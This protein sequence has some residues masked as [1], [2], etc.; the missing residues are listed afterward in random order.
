M[1]SDQKLIRMFSCRALLAAF[2][3]LT[4]KYAHEE[5]KRMKINKQT[6]NTFWEKL[7][8]M[9]RSTK[10]KVSGIKQGES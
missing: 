7:H 5:M 4:A 3:V 6:K 10:G 2:C 1:Q 8:K 9:E